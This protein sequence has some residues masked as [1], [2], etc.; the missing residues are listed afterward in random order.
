MKILLIL[1]LTT[2]SSVTTAA[3][4]SSILLLNVTPYK[5]STKNF[6]SE[7]LTSKAIAKATNAIDLEKII[8]KTVMEKITPSR[9]DLEKYY[10][11]PGELDTFVKAAVQKAIKD[12]L[13]NVND[14][15][16]IGFFKSLGNNLIGKFADKILDTEGIK[17]PARRLL[18]VEKITAPFNECISSSTNFFYD[19]DQCMTA[20]V[21]NMA[22]N[23]GLG[24]VFELSR[25]NLNSNLPENERD[26]F[27]L[28]QVKSYTACVGQA[29]KGKSGGS[30]M[31]CALE[32]MKNGVLKVT[33]I[34]LT[35][36]INEKA[37]SEKNGKEIKSIV[38][39]TFSTCI[40][41]VG[42]SS[43]SSY[44]DQIIGC[45]DNLVVETGTKLVNENV[46][47]LD[48]IKSALDT[49][50]ISLLAVEKS[51]QF[52][53]CAENQ[54]KNDV[55]NNGMV[56]INSCVNTVTNEITFKVVSE[57]LK[58]S[59]LSTLK[60]PKDGN[61]LAKNVGNDGVKLLGQCWNNQ[62]SEND[63][64][65]C[66]RKTIVNFSQQVAMLKL[67]SAIPAAMPGKEK[68]RIGSTESLGKCLEKDLPKNISSSKDFSK[69]LSGCTGTLTKTVALE[70]A[71]FE[72][73]SAAQGNISSSETE[74]LIN[75]LVKKDFT[76]CLGDSPADT[77]LEACTNT[78]SA[79]AGKKISE[80][81][82]SK[83]V[84]TYLEKNGG[85]KALGLTQ[86]Q[87]NSFLSNL[88]LTTNSCIDTKP[89]GPIMDQVNLC[90]K[91]SIKK[92]ALFF[93]ETQFNKSVG[94]MYTD[95]AAD[96]KVVEDNFKKS[97][98]VC[99]ATKDGKEFS[100]TDF[101][102][103]LYTCSDK[104]STATTLV[105]GSDQVNTS[106]DSY[107]KDRPGMD[108]KS[109]RDSIRSAVLG[110]FQSCMSKTTAQNKCIDA[111]KREATSQIVLNYG[112]IEVK[113]QLNADQ[114]PPELAPIET[115]LTKC[116][117]SK[118]EGDALSSHLDECTKDFAL[119]FARA[120]G[121]LK[122]NY[123]LKQALGSSEYI[124]Q[125]KEID[126]SL[127][128]YNVCLDDLKK[129][130][131][132]DGLTVKLSACTDGLTNRG[133][134][135]VR[136]NISNWMTTEKKDAATVMIKQEFANFLPCL[137]ALLPTSPYNQKLQDNIDSSVK[138]LA[139][140]LSHYIE[141]NP[142]N[143]REALGGI[144]EKLSV[145]F[146]DVAAT[147]KAKKDLLNFLYD[148]QGLDQFIKAMVRGTVK[149]GLSSV[150][151][152]DVPTELRN[153]LL[154]RENYEEIF[155]SPEGS[156]IK[157]LVMEKLLRPAL[158]ENVDPKSVVFKADMEGIKDNVI[159]LLLNAPNF[160]EQ[161]I[162]MS[163]QNQINS[164]GGVTKFFAKTLYG[165]NSLQW[166]KVRMTEAGKKAEEYIKEQ[167]LMPK[168]KGL[169]QT[170]AEQKKINEEAEKLV[171][172]AVKSYG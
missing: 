80:I 36:T 139:L 50:T 39:P 134:D 8:N 91:N 138:P 131:M 63:K 22:V 89:N 159:R 106:L 30:V 13:S 169:E 6:I 52:K 143:A 69:K 151:E 40:Q 109:K 172:K 19:A 21:D 20:M 132:S 105:V 163:I 74:T 57:T 156:R 160:G 61:A 68:L 116:T 107:L 137:S 87:V 25:E 101:T 153:I 33:N 84:N 32:A 92:I 66:L 146:N 7:N 48:S 56:D 16:M 1:V 167:V 166:D 14:K 67:D 168:F 2:L 42:A 113:T 130:G 45:I 29:P 95:R 110:N 82:F 17:D 115:A 53:I 44:K 104:I 62:Q 88:N 128:K 98:T 165:V 93:G 155:N 97:L 60:N 171:K 73:K 59:A 140:L 71:P 28:N 170:P 145:D 26:Q 54:K 117:N 81:S 43:K 135:L 103:N 41:K 70:V 34:S 35:K 23:A 18:W 142:E 121:D 90:L 119:G 77:Q 147:T 37:T 129:I 141:Y 49:K 27:N 31:P 15:N 65:S 133:M 164:M 136:N 120:L 148:H 72:I 58:A 24:I 85:L 100:I 86:T 76:A 83:E 94:N 125:K 38:F 124:A 112:R 122:L 12:N 51:K 157:D 55:R 111:L 47:N 158:I 78:L 149:E 75:E 152:K 118:L 11:R 79:K 102:K 126:R 150:S 144:I 5:R 108:L 96:K 114:M 4:I 46:S 99:L 161:A 10:P 9:K 127:E 3:D 162:K 123:L 154:K 64:E